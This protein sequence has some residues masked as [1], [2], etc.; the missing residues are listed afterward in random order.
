MN[1]FQRFDDYD[2]IGWQLCFRVHPNSWKLHKSQ[3]NRLELEAFRQYL[4]FLGLVGGLWAWC[5]R[6][7]QILSQRV[8]GLLKKKAF[9]IW[10][11]SCQLS[12]CNKKACDLKPQRETGGVFIRPKWHWDYLYTDEMIKYSTEAALLVLNLV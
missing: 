1:V 10:K 12:S 11:K 9:A 6:L 3:T 5:L 4:A 8:G 2:A 7:K